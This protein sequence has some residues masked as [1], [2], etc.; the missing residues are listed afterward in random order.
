[1]LF[2]SE[3]KSIAKKK[4]QPEP[5]IKEN[6]YIK[7]IKKNADP[8]P[9]KNKAR[10]MPSDD[11]DVPRI[12]I[13]VIGEFIGYAQEETEVKEEPE[14]VPETQNEGEENKA[15]IT[16]QHSEEVTEHRP[17]DRKQNTDDT[18]DSKTDVKESSKD[19]LN[20]QLKANSQEPSGIG[21]KM[22][23]K[24][25]KTKHGSKKD[26]KKGSKKQGNNEE[27]RACCIIV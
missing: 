23:A 1:M 19:A 6:K 13:P 12:E 24:N 5:N 10:L 21:D 25:K 17:R 11:I 16:H 27:G 9:K 3:V 26:T 18:K 15:K 8:E 2:R 14:T 22:D 20:A 7:P 4:K